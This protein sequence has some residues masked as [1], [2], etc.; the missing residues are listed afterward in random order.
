M[1]DMC[2]I[3]LFRVIGAAFGTFDSASKISAYV[4]SVM[5]MF[6]GYQITKTQ[7]HPWLGW[8]YWVSPLAYDFEALLGNE[9]HLKVIHGAGTNLVPHGSAHT[10]DSDQNDT[11]THNPGH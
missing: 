8:L 3:A 5:A 7:T 1:N 11:R 9:L 4:I 10:N 2:S 6:T